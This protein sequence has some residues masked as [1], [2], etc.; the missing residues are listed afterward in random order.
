MTRCKHA[1]RI[2]DRLII[3]SAVTFNGSNLIINI[4]SGNYGNHC[5]YCI[6]V[7][8]SIPAA[9]TI[10]APVYITIGTSTTLYPLQ[11]CDCVQATACQ[12]RTRTKYPVT[13]VTTAAG[14]SFRLMSKTTCCAPNNTIQSLPAPAVAAATEAGETA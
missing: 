1:C 14:G 2:C 11:R 10:N 12:I 5:R 6:V 7:A 4:P 3:S 13:V 8:Q 9:A